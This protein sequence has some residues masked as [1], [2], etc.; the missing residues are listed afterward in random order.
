MPVR[1]SLCTTYLVWGVV[2]GL[3]WGTALG[4]GCASG[5]PPTATELGEAA[6]AEGDWSRAATHFADALRHDSR[7]ARAWHGQARA[8]LLGRNPESALRSLSKL[9][10]LD[11]DHFKQRA[12]ATYADTLDAAAS[13]RL[14]RGQARSAL[15]AARALARI[16]PGRRGLDRL[17][18]RTLLAEARRRRWLGDREMALG[19]YQEAC[20]VTPGS[21]EAWVA[22]A[23]ILL[24]KRK[25][26]EAMRVLEEARLHHPTAGEIRMLSLQ[27]LKGR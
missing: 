7:D 26:K 18:G 3:V 21:L 25:T 14:A 22:T 13:D 5:P 12:R 19:L 8:E 27:A 6:L 9:A 15:E 10:K 23:E 4:A 24:E 1:T 11:P 2:W 16:E 17:L 20:G